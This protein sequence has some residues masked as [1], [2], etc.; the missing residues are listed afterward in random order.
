M[1]GRDIAL[2]AAGTADEKKGTNVVVYDL[3]GLVDITDY[4]VVA[5]AQSKSQTRAIIETISRR[6]K[7]AGT[8]KM[9]QEG[10]ENG[11]W[12][13]IDYCD[14]IVHV[15]SPNLREYYALESL[16]GDAPK[17]DWAKDSPAILKKL[18]PAENDSL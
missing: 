7:Q 12:V 8:M 6:L 9:G 11:N 18:A 1:N 13:L 14:C 5:T 3:R 4:M 15:F 10:N 17:M 2:F 16:W